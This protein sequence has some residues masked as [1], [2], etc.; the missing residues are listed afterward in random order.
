MTGLSSRDR[1]VWVVIGVMLAGH[2]VLAFDTARNMSVTHDEYWHLPV[3]LLNWK[4]GRFEFDT[5]NPP[6]VKM[7]AALPLLATDARAP[8]IET[9]TAPAGY[10]DRFQ[11]ANHGRLQQLFLIGRC[12]IVLLSVFTGLILALWAWKLFGPGS[13]CLTA[14]L[15]SGSPTVLAHASLVTTDL[16]AAALFTATLFLLWNFASQPSLK[17]ALI[18]GVVLGLAQITKYT[19]LLLYP[20]S[21][22]LW[23]VIRYRNRDV[24]SVSKPVVAV[25]WTAALLVSLGTLNTGYLFGGSF[26]SLESYHFVSKDLSQISN[27]LNGISAVPVPFPRD[28]LEGLDQQRHIMEQKH[29]VFLDQRWSTEGFGNYYLMAMLY[30]LPHALQLLI[31]SSAVFLLFPGREERHTR[32]QLV[33]LLPAISLIAI[34][35]F[36]GM[37]LGLRYILPAFPFLFLFAGQTTRWLRWKQTPFRSLALS[38]LIVG[39]LLPLGNHPHHLAYFNEYAG[40]PDEGRDHLLD[41][42][43]DWGQDLGR[44]KEFVEAHQIDDLH[45]AY[46]GTMP[47]QEYGIRFRLPASRHP[48]P[49]WYA[50]SVNFVQGRPHVVRDGKGQSRSV[51]LDEFGYFRFFHEKKQSI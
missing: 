48:E 13:A 2:A 31:L 16:G 33:L 39:M 22:M 30:K 3:G 45:L 9:P 26:S 10:G 50:V 32:V 27:A 1:L 40:G 25:Q 37:Q 5:L 41:S 47:P 51:G 18:F 21:I 42:N 12:M 14:L 15:W 38:A 34:A 24:S 49:G 36:S 17:S 43:L 7:F 4:T 44:L 29:P 46:F 8:S 19:C 23:F 35:S 28:Y 20:L 6:L 11:S